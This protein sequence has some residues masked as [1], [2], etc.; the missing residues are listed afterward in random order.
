MIYLQ[1]IIKKPYQKKKRQRG[2]RQE[3]HG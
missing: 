3:E 1:Q 2:P